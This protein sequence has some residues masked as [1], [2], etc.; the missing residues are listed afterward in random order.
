MRLCIRKSANAPCK[1]SVPTSLELLSFLLSA[2]SALVVS[3][4]R[5][6]DFV[7]TSIQCNL[8]S[9]CIA[10]V[11]SRCGLGKNTVLQ[12]YNGKYL[13]WTTSYHEVDDDF[14]Y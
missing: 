3:D 11:R 5:H 1:K 14:N 6:S 2:V 10:D 13:L 8:S 4:I 12:V 9:F 7:M